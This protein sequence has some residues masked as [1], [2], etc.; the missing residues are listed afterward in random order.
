MIT[1]FI[2]SVPV[3]DHGLTKSEHGTFRGCHRLTTVTHFALTRWI[4]VCFALLTVHLSNESGTTTPDA[5]SAAAPCTEP[6]RAVRTL[7]P[8]ALFL[9]V[10]SARY[11]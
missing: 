6:V 1:V 5:A 10:G 11:F 9:L 7:F 4:F 3:V 2:L 8:Q